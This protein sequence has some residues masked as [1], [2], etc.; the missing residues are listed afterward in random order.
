M[1]HQHQVRSEPQLS[2]AYGCCSSR[3]G[4][5]AAVPDR[6]KY[7]KNV[8]NFKDESCWNPIECRP[9]L[10]GVRLSQQVR[11]LAS[12]AGPDCSR[13][14]DT[15]SALQVLVE[16]IELWDP[17]YWNLHIFQSVQVGAVKLL[18]PPSRDQVDAC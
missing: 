14:A 16:D 10:F 11:T 6:N 12:S 15:P 3:L 1:G 8:I 18:P 9:R 4:L 13:A 5:T 2:P 7:E 17:I